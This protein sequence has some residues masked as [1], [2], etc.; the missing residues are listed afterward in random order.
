MRQFITTI[1]ATAYLRAI[2]LDFKREEGQALVEYALVLGL[3]V[4]G[5]IVVLGTLGTSVHTKLSQV[6]N[7]IGASPC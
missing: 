6:C 3:I 2:T 7:A 5:A 4:V 1:A